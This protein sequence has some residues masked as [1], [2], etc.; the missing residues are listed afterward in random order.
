MKK[1][2]GLAMILIL[3][4]TGVLLTGCKYAS[5]YSAIMLIT[6]NT[7]EKVYLSFSSISGTYVGTLKCKDEPGTLQYSA[8]IEEGSATVYVDYD[9]DKEE[10]FTI[11]AGEKIDSTL[12][13]LKKGKKYIIVETSE[14]CEDGKFEFNIK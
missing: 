9:G 1:K 12:E 10:L 14:T 3:V 11:N 5:H 6:T 13:D 2:T 7:S 4:L 8:E